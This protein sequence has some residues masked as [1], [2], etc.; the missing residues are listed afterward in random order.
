MNL[1]TMPIV[2]ILVGL[3]VRSRLLG[4]VL[5]L[6]IQ[7]IVFTFQTLAVLLAWRAGQ[8]VFGDATE[9]GVFGPAPTGIPIVFS[10]TE[11]WLYGLIN[12]VILSVGVALTVGIISLRAR[13]R[14]RTESTI[15][16]QPAV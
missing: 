13:R 12:V 3:F 5:Y 8:G 14:T 2:A 11:L 10:E 15:T 9:A 16:A 7:A 6:S 1:V 4:A